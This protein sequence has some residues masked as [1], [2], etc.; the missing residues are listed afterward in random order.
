MNKNKTWT[1]NNFFATSR[2]THMKQHKLE[3]QLSN[4]DL[5]K[6]VWMFNIF[7][8]INDEN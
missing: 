4:I 3:L 1:E 7:N 6:C 2:P 8:H 5:H